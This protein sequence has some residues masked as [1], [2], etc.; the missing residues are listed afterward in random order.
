MIRPAGLPSECGAHSTA[1]ARGVLPACPFSCSLCCSGLLSTRGRC[2]APFLCLCRVP[3]AVCRAGSWG[4]QRTQ[5]VT[6]DLGRGHLTGGP[7]VPRPSLCEAASHVS[8]PQTSKT[9]SQ[10]VPLGFL[11]S[12][13]RRS[14]PE[15]GALCSPTSAVSAVPPG[16]RA[17]SVR[18]TQF[19]SGPAGREPCGSACS[20]PSLRAALAAEG[21][22]ALALPCRCCAPQLT[23]GL[24]P[25]KPVVGGNGSGIT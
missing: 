8:H 25:E 6:A 14:S 5:P 21:I 19:G 17:A 12:D 15:S 10:H 18:R 7:S 20:L 22:V 23:V 4:L 11:P 9:P 3:H 16:P 1:Y 24:R 13:G 2:R